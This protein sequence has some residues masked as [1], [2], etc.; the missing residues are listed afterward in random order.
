MYATAD[1]S[2]YN[3]FDDQIFF[4]P[5]VKHEDLL[6]ILTENIDPEVLV[7]MPEWFQRLREAYQKRIGEAKSVD[8]SN[9][10]KVEIGEDEFIKIVQLLIKH[11][12]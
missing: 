8:Q 11:L 2:N 5:E 7:R 4:M 3:L 12:K 6:S 9:Q 10:T 1:R